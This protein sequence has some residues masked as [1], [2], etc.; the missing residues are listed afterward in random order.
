MSDARAMVDSI[1]GA[2]EPDRA[3]VLSDALAKV[4]AD[5]EATNSDALV[6]L[7]GLLA[8]SALQAG[9]DLEATELLLRDA[10]G[11]MAKAMKRRISASA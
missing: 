11:L 7:A 6:A 10:H 5:A 3:M 8:D 1:R 4:L 2:A 9:I